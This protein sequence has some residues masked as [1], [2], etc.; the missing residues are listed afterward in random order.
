MSKAVERTNEVVGEYNE[1]D[2][3]DHSGH[4]AYWCAFKDGYGHAEQE[5]VQ[6]IEEI[7]NWPP[8]E[9]EVKKI[10]RIQ[11]FLKGYK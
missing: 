9:N 10:L 5:I 6:K 3:T 4:N 8:G 7:I 2:W 11:E 1:G